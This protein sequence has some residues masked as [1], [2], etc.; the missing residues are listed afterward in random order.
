MTIKRALGATITLLA[1]AVAAAALAA[2]GS[3]SSGSTTASAGA[4]TSGSTSRAK[5]QA[6]LKQHGVTL[7]AGFGKRGAGANGAPPAGG[8]A[9]PSSG[10][11]SGSGQGGPPKG[12]FPAGGFGGGA[13]SARF[14]KMQAAFKACGA[15][16]GGGRRPGG[17]GG[18]FKPTAAAL[19]KFSACVK[20]HGYTLPRANTSGNGPIYPRS[21]E[22]NKKFQSAS[23]A[24]A[25]DLRPS[26]APPGGSSSGSNSSD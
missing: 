7:P 2:C 6:C 15:N 24:C 21:I 14:K 17:P 9:P 20:Q 10:G 13:N 16:F 25:S 26:G 22:S 11:S 18:N 5:L 8:G 12:G 4:S 3:S 23:K 1:V 19:S